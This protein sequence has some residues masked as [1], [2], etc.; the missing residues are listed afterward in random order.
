[1]ANGEPVGSFYWNSD[2]DTVAL[3]TN[4]GEIDLGE[5]LMF[6]AIN[7]SGATIMS[8]TVVQFAGALGSS[9]KMLIE[10][11]V[12]DG[13]V[14]AIQMLGIV[15]NTINDGDEGKVIMV[16]ELGDFDT[17]VY[18]LAGQILYIDPTTPGGLTNTEPTAPNLRYPIAATLDSKSNGNIIVRALYNP[19]LKQLNDVSFTSL[20]SG[21]LMLSNASGV[22]FN[23][24]A[25]S[26]INGL[27]SYA[28]LG[29]LAALN[30]LSY[31]SLLNLPS[32]GSL[33]VLNDLSYT[34]LL[35]LPSLGSL[36]VLNTVEYSNI[37]GLPSLGSLAVMNGLSLGSITNVNL[38]NPTANDLLKLD[39]FTGKWINT[40]DI[41]VDNITVN[42]SIV[43]NQSSA[44]YGDGSDGVI[45]FD[46]TNDYPN[47]AT[48]D[49]FSNY[50][51]IRDIYASDLN[52]A[53]F[54]TVKTA[55]Y[56]IFVS[57]SLV[58]AGTIENNGT[59]A[60]GRINGVGGTGGFFKAGG[61]GTLGLTTAQTGNG[62]APTTQT[63]LAGGVG[64]RGAG[65]YLNLVGNEGLD[66]ADTSV[67]VPSNA[68]GGSKMVNNIFA[69]QFSFIPSATNALLQFTPSI[70][71]GAGAKSA[72]GTG[73]TSGGGG[74]GGGTMF[75]AAR[76]FINFGTIS[77]NGGAGGDAAGTN[78]NIGGGGGGGGG[79]V[80]IVYDTNTTITLGDIRAQ[81]GYGGLSYD[82]SNGTRTI[83][84]SKFAV[85]STSQTVYF[86]PTTFLNKNSMYMLSV[87][88][89]GDT[90]GSIYHPNI[91]F[92]KIDSVDFNT[93][94]SPTETL[95]LWYG[96]HDNATP[97][98]ATQ[99][100][101]REI[102]V[103]TTNG[104]ATNMK[105][106]LDGLQN[107]DG[108]NLTYSHAVAS[109]DSTNNLS[110]DLGATPTTGNMVYSVFART[111][112]TTPV[113]GT[114]NTV[115]TNS[116]TIPYL[117]TEVS[118]NLQI[119]NH[120]WTGLTTAAGISVDLDQISSVQDGTPG[121]DGKVVL[122]PQ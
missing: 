17:S 90:I 83:A 60:V 119:N 111:G 3:S 5:D 61:N 91:E 41:T 105:I 116:N 39:E 13:S 22:W 64:G 45:D 107:I 115:V 88:I 4:G 54:V 113:V 110:V 78:A 74:G 51:L 49:G 2:R 9:G 99:L 77:A 44:F 35:N 86:K 96:Y 40:K 34:S 72:A 30:D 58:N 80:C 84:L 63:N 8:G 108:A 59:D 33:S 57:G 62:T 36:A 43:T 7:Q 20:A 95:E 92:Y 118:T 27:V 65:A 73:A 109:S 1:V 46:G 31:T 50:T 32:L 104:T 24:S 79:I 67:P 21:N 75:I 23:Y 52:V 112:G 48:F 56:R 76:T 28:S 19:S 85:A 68:I 106:V 55:G 12:A 120:R 25:S 53:F 121:W 18:G 114:G 93:I 16:G 100:E 94:A 37:S 42:G 102:K 66:I 14:P 103:T 70:G 6:Y 87:H 82:H 98:V 47:F 71:G 38:S 97:E 11:A 69:Y 10:P 29:S 26:L 89:V 15:K 101:N 122:L 81:G 117:Y